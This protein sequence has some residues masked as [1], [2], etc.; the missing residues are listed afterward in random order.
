VIRHSVDVSSV[1]KLYSES[2]SQL[3]EHSVK[4]REHVCERRI[5]EKV[6]VDDMQ[7]GF[8]PRKGTIDARQMQ[9]NIGIKELLS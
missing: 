1:Y 8:R 5:M 7:F 6:I 2:C 3:L 9:I 4:V